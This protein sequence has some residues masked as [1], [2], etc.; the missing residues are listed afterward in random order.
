MSGDL[1]QGVHAL[2]MVGSVV[3][4]VHA[5]SV[6]AELRELCN[7]ALAARSI[8]D[9]ILCVG[10]AAC[11]SR[12]VLVFS[13][14]EMLS[15]TWLIVDTTDV[16]TLVACEESCTVSVHSSMFASSFSHYAPLPLTVTA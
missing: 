15:H 8:G 2:V 7:V 16:K 9:R 6:N 12:S 11:P 1:Y 3:N 14:K 5:N 13:D 4:G 10:C